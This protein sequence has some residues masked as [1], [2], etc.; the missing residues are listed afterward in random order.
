MMKYEEKLLSLERIIKDY[1]QMA[2]A[3]SGGVDS[4]FLLLF[5][6]KVLGDQLIAVTASAPNFAPDEIAYARELCQKEGIRHLIVDLGAE[7]LSQ[8]S[9]NPPD[10][11]Y[12]CKKAI[13]SQVKQQVA[14]QFPHAVIVD[15]TNLDDMK[16][17]RPGHKALAELSIA[18]PLKEA[19]LTKAEI[20]RA[21]KE[22]GGD[23]W[24]KPAFA[25]LASR[26]PYGETLTPEKLAAVYRAESVLRDL[27]FRQVRVRCHGNLARIEVAPEDR[28]KFFDLQ[29]MD[30][31]SAL[32]KEAGFFYVTLD[33]IGYRMGSLNEEIQE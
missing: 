5:S 14:A 9:H 2:L 11:C 10:R 19:G 7:I 26:I 6:K 16:D 31:V 8:F 25:C 30:R 33:L 17:Y 21:L 18:S 20:R 1:G 23:I 28:K 29:F 15:G 13:F 22:L 12:I 24:D 4:T 3:L 27:G 32:V